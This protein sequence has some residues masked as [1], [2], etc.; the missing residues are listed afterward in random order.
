MYKI[1]ILCLT[2]DWRNK[3]SR[4]NL[5]AGP[6]NPCPL[7]KRCSRKQLLSNAAAAKA[8]IYVI[9][10]L[11]LYTRFSEDKIY[12]LITAILLIPMVAVLILGSKFNKYLMYGV[13]LLY[14]IGLGTACLALST[15]VADIEN[16]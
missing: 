14:I 9:S 7:G 3:S 12:I 15:F 16:R 2:V 11:L 1:V 4:F 8:A 6:R 5:G 13:T 10:I